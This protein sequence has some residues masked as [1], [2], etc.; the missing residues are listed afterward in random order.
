MDQNTPLDP[1]Q[2]FSNLHGENEKLALLLFSQ[3]N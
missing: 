2:G 1:R 3:G